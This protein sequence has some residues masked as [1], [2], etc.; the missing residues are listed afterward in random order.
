MQ[1]RKENL[2]AYERKF[3]LKKI[4]K[5]IIWL[6]FIYLFYQL[7]QIGFQTE[8]TVSDKIGVEKVPYQEFDYNECKTVKLLHTESRGSRRVAIGYLL[9][10]S[11]EC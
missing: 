10:W 4:K 8:E 9:V 5:I 2:K 3:D 11:S 7:F 1:N 6:I